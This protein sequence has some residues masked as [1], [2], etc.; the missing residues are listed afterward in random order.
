[1]KPSEGFGICP[2]TSDDCQTSDVYEDK[3]QEKK[4]PLA[5]NLP[6][7]AR[8]L[9]GLAPGMLLNI[10]CFPTTLAHIYIFS[11]LKCNIYIMRLSEPQRA[12]VN[13]EFNGED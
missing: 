5:I 8:L 7:I 9:F 3:S 12:I 4:S 2:D 10:C 13:S 1:M 6:Y 11:C